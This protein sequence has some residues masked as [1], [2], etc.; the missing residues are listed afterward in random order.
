MVAHHAN[1]PRRRQ[2]PPAPRRRK[3]FLR[4]LAVSCRRRGAASCFCE[5][6]LC[7]VR[8]RHI[9]K[10][11]KEEDFLCRVRTRHIFSKNVGK[12]CPGAATPQVVF[13]KAL[14]CHVR[15]RHIFKNGKEED[16][17]CHV[18]TRQIFSK[19]GKDMDFFVSCAHTTHFQRP[20]ITRRRLACAAIYSAG[21]KSWRFMYSGNAKNDAV[22]DWHNPPL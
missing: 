17:L 8:T 15:T 6:L 12:I 21:K 22:C 19:N 14:L 11:G 4:G 2:D 10:D 13:A 20:N 7:H 9:F 16:F 5:G 1:D 18:R 3:L